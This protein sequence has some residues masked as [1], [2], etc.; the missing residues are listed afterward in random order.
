[1]LKLLKSELQYFK[2]LYILSLLFVIFVNLGMTIDGRWIEAQDDFPGLRIIWLG[3]GIV[4]LFGF[5]HQFIN[6]TIINYYTYRLTPSVFIQQPNPL[7]TRRTAVW[8]VAC[9]FRRIAVTVHLQH[10]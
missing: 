7:E 6:A 9:D 5:H 2:W 1:M 4:V 8:N 10:I 3:I